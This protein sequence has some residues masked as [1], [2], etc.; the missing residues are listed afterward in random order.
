M[1]EALRTVTI[2]CDYLHPRFAAAYLL[3]QG[4][5]AAFIDNN[6]QYAVPRLLDSL[7]AEGLRPEQVDYVIITHVHLDHASGSAA[8][9][10]A[11]PNATL[12]AHPRAA[13]HMIDPSK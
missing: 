3:R 12:L 2:D 6:T 10:E 1:S 5:R 4:D 9:M 7:K 13:P 11:C 8:L